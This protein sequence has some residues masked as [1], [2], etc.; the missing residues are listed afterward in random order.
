MAQKS[1]PSNP[2]VSI[3]IPVYNGANYIAEAIES[4]LSQTWSN[5]EVIVVEDGSTDGGST[6]AICA[7]Y[8]DRIRYFYKVNGGVSTALNFGIEVMRGQFFSWLSHDDKYLPDRIKT[9]VTEHQRQSSF[10]SSSKP[11]VLFSDVEVIDENGSIQRKAYQ[12]LPSSRDAISAAMLSKINGCSLLIPRKCFDLA[13]CFH[14]KLPTTQDND[15]WVRFTEVANIQHVPKVTVQSRRHP[16]QGSHSSWHVIERYLNKLSIIERVEQ[17]IA[18]SSGNIRLDLLEKLASSPAIRQMPGIGATAH[19]RLMKAIEH[20]S[21]TILYV[22]KQCPLTIQDRRQMRLEGHDLRTLKLQSAHPHELIQQAASVTTDFVWLLNGRPDHPFASI[23][24]LKQALQTQPRAAGCITSSDT[25]NRDEVFGPFEGALL[26]PQLFQQSWCGPNQHWADIAHAALRLGGFTHCKV[27]KSCRVNP[28]Q[29]YGSAAKNHNWLRYSD[30]FTGVADFSLRRT[31]IRLRSFA[32]RRQS[33]VSRAYTKSKLL[34]KSN[35]SPVI[36]NIRWAI[37]RHRKFA[38]VL[39]HICRML[40]RSESLARLR[41]SR[42]YGLS[43]FFD[44][45]WYQNAY[46]DVKNSGVDPLWHYVNQ[47][48]WEQRD[49]CAG[50]SAMSYLEGNPDVMASTYPAVLHYAFMGRFQSRHVTRSHCAPVLDEAIQRTEKSATYQHRKLLLI[51]IGMHNNTARFCHALIDQISSDFEIATLCFNSSGENPAMNDIASTI[52]S[53]SALPSS[54][55]TTQLSKQG[56]DKAIVVTDSEITF[57]LLDYLPTLEQSYDFYWLGHDAEMK[58]GGSVETRRIINQASQRLTLSAVSNHEMQARYPNRPWRKAAF[59]P[60]GG[61][62]CPRPWIRA[63]KPNE[64]HR[65]ALFGQFTH[66][67]DMDLIVKVLQR[68]RDKKLPIILRIFGSVAHELSAIPCK[69]IS[70]IRTTGQEQLISDVS[71]FDPHVAWSPLYRSSDAVIAL[72]DAALTGLPLL[73]TNTHDSRGLLTDRPL[74]RLL[75]TTTCAR[76]WTWYLNHAHLLFHNKSS[77]SPRT[78]LEGLAGI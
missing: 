18:N 14:P 73:A 63:K 35:S 71:A 70:V 38:T 75:A 50:F 67:D 7:Q 2:L 12:A 26:K 11:L 59:P 16:A 40:S 61:V 47:G 36:N 9:M 24:L 3:V 30:I 43:A 52:N 13:G 49:P 72:H 57:H 54:K 27:T 10:Q 53:P 74:T 65:I 56:F 29:D 55:L 15:M 48:M 22:G 37:L 51:A 1:N 62:T 76:R 45:D 23:S 58:S 46:S 19:A 78:P 60:P 77:W 42:L 20:A 68:I 33:R 25:F 44:R 31:A 32:F 21:I 6:A 69:D 41:V 28:I 8:K 39:N 66:A 5:T 17:G 64:P 4:A 34:I